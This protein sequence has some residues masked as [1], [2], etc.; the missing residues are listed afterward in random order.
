[1]P[2]LASYGRNESGNASRAW[3]SGVLALPAAG[4]FKFIF[5]GLV[6]CSSLKASCGEI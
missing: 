4:L 3:I 6:A 5:H 2:S 1:M